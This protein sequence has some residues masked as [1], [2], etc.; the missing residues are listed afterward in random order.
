M[1]HFHKFTLDTHKKRNQH[2]TLT[3]L[4]TQKQ[5]CTWAKT[6]AKL[7][8]FEKKVKKENHNCKQIKSCADEEES[9]SERE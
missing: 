2:R 1:T 4:G 5:R 7:L 8:S 6:E 3:H 9:E